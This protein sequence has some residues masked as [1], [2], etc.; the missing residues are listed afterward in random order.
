M[1]RGNPENLQVAA[2]RK[3]D[4]AI[5]RATIGLQAL[6]RSGDPVTFRG[7]AKTAGVSVDFL[8]RCQLR[9]RIEQLRAQRQSTP[10]SPRQIEIAQAPSQSNVVRTLAAQLSQ[11][12]QQ[13]RAEVTRLEAALAAAQGENLELRRRI[14]RSAPTTSG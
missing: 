6:E 8:Y 2:Q 13:H 4:A 1:P 14:S 9:D 3:R 11:L 7:L 12:K 10:P 5:Q